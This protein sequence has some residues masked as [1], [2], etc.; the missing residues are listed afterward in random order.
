MATLRQ[1]YGADD[2]HLLLVDTGVCIANAHCSCSESPIS[3]V[4]LRAALSIADAVCTP[5]SLQSAQIHSLLATHSDS[6]ME[7]SFH[8]HAALRINVALRGL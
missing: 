2:S 3:L 4:H 1:L 6:L 7:M 8:A 5:E